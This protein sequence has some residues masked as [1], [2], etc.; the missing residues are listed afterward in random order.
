MKFLPYNP[1]QAY[2]L[3]PSVREVLGED[4]ICFFVHQVVERLELSALEQGYVEEGRPAYHPV[5]L[6]KVWLY[7]Y[8]LGLTSA[9][10]LE[11]R[12]REDLAF[13]PPG[14]WGH[15]GFLDPQPVPHAACP[16]AERS[17]H[18]G[19]GVGAFA[20]YGSAGARR[21]RLDAGG[22]QCLVRAVETMKKL[23]SERAKVRRQIR[24]W[25]KQCNTADPEEAPGQQVAPEKMAALQQRLEEIPRRLEQ[26]RKVG[27]DKVSLTDA[28]S[29]F[30][31][32]RKGFTLGYTATA[33]V[34][35]D[36]LI[37]EQRV[38]QNPTDNAML[39]PVV[40]AVEQHCRERPQKVSADSGYFRLETIVELAQR[41]LDVYVPDSNLARE[42]NR[43]K[44]A[45]EAPAV[46]H[47]EHRRMRRK[48]RDPKLAGRFISGARRS[49]NPCSGF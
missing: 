37:V 12:V 6:L 33:A 15:T 7:A 4:H 35:E 39:V 43:G 27:R 29:R 14:G 2:L 21:R 9:R 1:E 48:L 46:R 38:G 49:W 32:D 13:R 10:R 42:L 36:H 8:V 5:L 47:P 44:R 19:G 31:R 28:D 20:R 23:R 26:L 17:V 25:Q 34:S 40:E 24:R 22:G 3:P 45:P 18:A 41:G 11:Q 16:G 30:L